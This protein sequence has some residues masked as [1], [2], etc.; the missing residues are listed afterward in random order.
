MRIQIK[1]KYIINT[2]NSNRDDI[3]CE[4]RLFIPSLN[5]EV[6]VKENDME[7][8]EQE[9]A[10][11]DGLNSHSAEALREEIQKYANI[12]S[13]GDAY[14]ILTEMPMITPRGRFDV[15][16]L[17]GN[18]KIHGPS[19][20]YKITYKNISR[21]FLLP[22]QDGVHIDLVVALEKPLRQGN[23]TYP[24]L[25]FQCKKENEKTIELNLPEDKNEREALLKDNLED[26]ISGPTYD[27]MARLFK[28]FVGVG[29]IIPGN[30]KK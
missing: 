29:V 2:L 23:T 14:A 28:A 12:G 6:E 1:S 30:F 17:K 7:V 21:V 8:E 3:L 10:P 4:M 13:L 24:F 11:E 26:T 5:A 18:L 19:H 9:K 20:D 16:M 27:I 22:R 15:Q 25:I